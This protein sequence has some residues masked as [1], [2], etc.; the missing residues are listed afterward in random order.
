MKT[1]TAAAV[2]VLS[3]L[4]AAGAAEAADTPRFTL[5][6]NGVFVPTSID[7]ASARTFRAFAEEGR[8]DDAYDA[9]TGPGFEAGLV[10]HFSRRFGV[11]VAGGVASRDTGADYDLRVPHPLYLSR[12]RTADGTLAVDYQEQQAHLDLVYTG[13]SGSLDFTLFAGPTYFSVSSDL[14]GEPQYS[15]AYPFD[16]I[17]VT[18]VPTPSSDDTGMGFNAG[19]GISYR[20]SKSVGFGVQGRFSRASVELAPAGGQSV[21]IDAGGLQ[22]AGGLRVFF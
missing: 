14:L 19:A 4:L 7:Y 18:S 10:W 22:V 9:G 17:T 12:D 5:S 20:F 6:V 21:K 15:Q 8:L 3:C 13:R 16:T 1:T 2:L 11:G